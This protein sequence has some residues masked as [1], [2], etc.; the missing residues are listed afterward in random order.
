MKPHISKIFMPKKEVCKK[1]SKSPPKIK[2][3]KKKP[4]ASNEQ[5]QESQSENNSTAIKKIN[6]SS[7]TKKSSI[8]DLALK[9]NDSSRG[10]RNS[11]KP[12]RMPS[13]SKS[14]E[15]VKVQISA[16]KS[17]QQFEMPEYKYQN[18]ASKDVLA[19]YQPN[20]EEKLRE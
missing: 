5:S 9:I 18:R 6:Q 7:E 20:E 15:L 13:R 16:R 10:R 2:T 19:P 4:Q 3:P 11:R 12:P 17:D 14:S 1:R 8:T